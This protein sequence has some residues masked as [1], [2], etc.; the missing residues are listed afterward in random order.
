M[1]LHTKS[2]ILYV[3][4]KNLLIIVG[5]LLSESCMHADLLSIFSLT[6]LPLTISNDPKA[7]TEKS[8]ENT[9][10]GRNDFTYVHIIQLKQ[11]S[12]SITIRKL[13]RVVN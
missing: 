12:Q 11:F 4:K 6:M 1:I 8:R 7:R 9:I 2:C 13:A 3:S 10:V 5:G